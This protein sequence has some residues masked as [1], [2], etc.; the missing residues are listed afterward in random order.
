MS[1]TPDTEEENDQQPNDK[2]KQITSHST[3][4][5][6]S[7]TDWDRKII[8]T[9]NIETEVKDV[10][11]YSSELRTAIRQLGGYVANEQFTSGT[12]KLSASLTLKVPVDMFEQ[13]V[14]LMSEKDNIDQQ[15]QYSVVGY[16]YRVSGCKC[17]AGSAPLDA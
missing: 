6:A 16:K 9:A 8:R 3:P 14:A 10:K 15:H 1:Y 2:K 12:Y 7:F 17:A 11:L 13:A 5:P 4:T